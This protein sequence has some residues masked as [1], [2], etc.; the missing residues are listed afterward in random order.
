MSDSEYERVLNTARIVLGLLKRSETPPEPPAYEA[1]FGA[2]SPDDVPDDEALRDLVLK[3]IADDA[4]RR[5]RAHQLGD[6]LGQGITEIGATLETAAATA[7]LYAKSLASAQNEVSGASTPPALRAVLARL[8]EDTTRTQRANKLL[9][10]RVADAAGY[11][12]A[13]RAQIAETRR[14][15][16]IDSLT[17][18]G[19]RRHFDSLAP[20]MIATAT[21]ANAPL[22]LVLLDVDHFRRFNETYGHQIGDEVLR[23]IARVLTGLTHRAD[24]TARIGGE[25]FAALLPGCDLE[26]AMAFGERLREQLG[27]QTLAGSSDDRDMERITASYGVTQLRVGDSALSLIER[28]D[29]CLYAAKQA[30]RDRIVADHDD[31]MAEGIGPAAPPAEADDDGQ[32]LLDLLAAIN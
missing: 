28:A 21:A 20:Q 26:A 7:S 25:E 5:D 32:S 2:L 4:D 14:D 27:L 8:I 11:I 1:V 15:A 10:R 18:I 24:L 31:D 22:S 16:S 12:E 9:A 13:V 3:R 19:N 23:V 6:E 29:R 30:G 17:R